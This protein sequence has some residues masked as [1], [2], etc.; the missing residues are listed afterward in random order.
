MTTTNRPLMVGNTPK[1]TTPEMEV[2]LSTFLDYRVNLIVPNVYWGMNIHECDL[3]VVSKAGYLT[4]IEIK[5]TR[6][7]LRADAKKWH[8]HESRK[9]KR[10]FF[11]L[12]DY[13]EHCL[14]M[15]PERAGI[16]LVRPNTDL[17]E[18]WVSPPRCREIRPAKR[19]P[20]ASK[21]SDADRYKI[22][23]L[24]A[25]RIWGLKRAVLKAADHGR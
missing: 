2:A 8:G 17:S 10:L 5:V 18:A 23:R 7:D 13:L 19:N 12:P 15:V 1:I 6:A 14:D 3:L 11:A 25:L 21:I 9:I 24:G 16:I 22:A 4:E 20:A